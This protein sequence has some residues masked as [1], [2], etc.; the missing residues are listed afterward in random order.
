MPQH[1]NDL[2]NHTGGQVSSSF[3]SALAGFAT[4]VLEGRT[5]PSVRPFFFGA[6][7]TALNKKGGG[8]RGA[9][10]VALLLRLQ[11]IRLGMTWWPF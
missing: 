5:P 2:L 11:G 7:L 6:A 3:F 8:V 1:L 10:C 9:L 4:L